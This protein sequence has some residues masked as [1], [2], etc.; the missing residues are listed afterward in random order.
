MTLIYSFSTRNAKERIGLQVQ[1]AR[2][3]VAGREV[4]AAASFSQTAPPQV[5][6]PRG[7]VNGPLNSPVAFRS[8]PTGIG[9]A[10][11]IVSPPQVVAQRGSSRAAVA[12]PPIA[13]AARSALWKRLSQEERQMVHSRM[14][15]GFETNS[16]VQISE[17]QK[18]TQ[19][20][21]VRLGRGTPLGDEEINY[22]LFLLQQREKEKFMGTKRILILTTQFFAKLMS[23][24]PE[25]ERA[26]PR[27]N[28]HN[29]QKWMWSEK[30]KKKIDIF[31]H[32]MVFVPIHESPYHWLG[33]MIYMKDKR[34]SAFDSCNTGDDHGG[35]YYH[36]IILQYLQDEH[37]R[38][39][40]AKLPQPG[41]WKL[42]KVKSECPQQVGAVDCGVY[43]CLFADLLSRKLALEFSQAD[44]PEARRRIALSILKNKA[45]H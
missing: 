21:F 29:V 3:P 32:E 33:L 7:L 35:K 39:Y 17:N 1:A 38:V 45:E 19:S 26:T 31:Q 14:C 27:Y 8:I 24:N 5:V 16:V 30:E 28:Y 15:G 42:E 36:R 34:I 10:V 2:R 18:V 11:P 6:S 22:Y 12:A 40:N 44:I 23:H 9:S 41:E 20:S 4:Q 13:R 37:Q 43:L 25:S